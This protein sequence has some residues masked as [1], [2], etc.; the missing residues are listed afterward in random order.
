MGGVPLDLS[1]PRVLVASTWHWW[2]QEPGQEAAAQLRVFGMPAG[3][4][5]ER[6]E[7]ERW[8]LRGSRARQLAQS[9]GNCVGHGE[10][11]GLAA[12]GSCSWQV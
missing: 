3:T 1:V 11:E 5:L 4:Q 7:V 10:E 12:E 2:Q 6:G 9:V 8:T